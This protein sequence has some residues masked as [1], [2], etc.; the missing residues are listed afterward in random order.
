MVGQGADPDGQ[1]PEHHLLCLLV[2]S[3][4]SS[5]ISNASNIETKYQLW[6]VPFETFASSEVTLSLSP[7]ANAIK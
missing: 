5:L 6:F 2:A 4:P 7:S 1:P 3:A